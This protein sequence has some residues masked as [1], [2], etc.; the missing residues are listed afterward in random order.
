MEQVSDKQATENTDDET[1]VFLSDKDISKIIAVTP[2]WM[3]KQR[4]LRKY[5]EDHIFTIDPVFIGSLPRYRTSEV[6]AWI[7]SIG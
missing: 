3:R 6:K 4:H 7:D 5:G 1:T 2:S